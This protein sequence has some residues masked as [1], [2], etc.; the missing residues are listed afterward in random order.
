MNAAL[1]P[2]CLASASPQRRDILIELGF[3]G[4]T[5]VPVFG[6]E[7]LLPGD[8][9]ET[10]RENAKR[11]ALGARIPSPA[12]EQAVVIAADTLMVAADGSVLG[13]P[14][15]PERAAEYLRRIS[16]SRVRVCTGVAALDV[17]SRRGAVAVAWSA[18]QLKPMSDAE[19][20][21]YVATG[22]PLD[23]AGGFGI[24][25]RGEIFVEELEGEYSCFAGLP[26]RSLHAVL[27]ALL[28]GHP[29]LP[30]A[31]GRTAVEIFT[32]PGE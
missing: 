25:R 15:T 1:P 23:R 26:K 8:P 6:V 14:E 29:A 21:W 5:I 18:A 16:G 2:L 22:E 30:P 11:K 17:F 32:A 9:A 13:K 31:D 3:G 10:V 12:G 7:E 4:F 24:S 20:A 28:P 19:I 27:A